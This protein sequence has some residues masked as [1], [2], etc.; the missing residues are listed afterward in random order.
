MQTRLTYMYR[1]AGNYKQHGEAVFEGEITDAEKEI[2][3]R[4]CNDGEYFIA[5]Q[6]GLEDLQRDMV[7]FPDEDDHVWS[8]FDRFE[9]TDRAATHDSIHEFIRSMD[10]IKWE[11]L[12]AIAR[13]RSNSLSWSSR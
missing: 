11:V 3:V 10:G 9:L 4:A 1:D 7:A 13:L 6:V 12:G 2:F 5:S 8:E